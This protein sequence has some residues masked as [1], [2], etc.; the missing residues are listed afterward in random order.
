M[1]HTEDRMC[2]TNTRNEED[3][4]CALP[5]LS[6]NE[7]MPDYKNIKIHEGTHERLKS[8]GNMGESFDDLI[9]RILDDWEDQDTRSDE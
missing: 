7:L 5:E 9:N 6:S 1:K 8:H 2:A 4:L 3:T